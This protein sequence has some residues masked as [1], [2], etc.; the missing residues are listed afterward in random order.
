VAAAVLFNVLMVPLAG[1]TGAA[2]A[3]V[4]GEAGLLILMGKAM[5]EMVSPKLGLRTLAPLVAA[6]AMAV[7]V[8]LLRGMNLF[9]CVGFG[10]LTYSVF[11]LLLRGVTSDDVGLARNG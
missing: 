5:F 10:I 1:S 8:Y 11:L 4:A 2:I 6:V 9:A 7:V 3:I